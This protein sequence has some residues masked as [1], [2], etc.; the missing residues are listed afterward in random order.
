MSQKS[1][2]SVTGSMKE[3]KSLKKME[4]QTGQEDEEARRTSSRM[5]IAVYIVSAC[6]V[7]AL[8]FLLVEMTVLLAMFSPKAFTMTDEV[9]VLLRNLNQVRSISFVSSPLRVPLLL[10]LQLL[11][12]LQILPCCSVS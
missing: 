8:V 12:R 4:S 1:L 9:N 5:P 7:M 6:L 3:G 11:R 2:L 10:L